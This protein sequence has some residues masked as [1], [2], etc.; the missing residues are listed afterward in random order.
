MM[1]FPPS[2]WSAVA[3]IDDDILKGGVLRVVLIRWMVDV[4]STNETPMSIAC[5]SIVYCDGGTV[6]H[7]FL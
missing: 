1:M 4:A 7:F 2:G 5:V 3:W 6:S